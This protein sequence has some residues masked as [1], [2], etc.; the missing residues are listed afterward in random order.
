ML[1]AGLQLSLGQSLT[2]TP[3]LQQ[4]IRLLQLSSIE[5]QAEIREQLEN[6]PMLEL[7]ESSD[8][9]DPQERVGS[10]ELRSDD[11]QT[12][13]ENA[14]QPHD[15]RTSHEAEL[16]SGQYTDD[17]PEDLPMDTRWD[18][19]YDQ[20]NTSSRHGEID[21]RDP[22]E[23][24]ADSSEGLIDHLAWQIHLSPLGAIERDIA[25]HIIE[26]VRPDGYLEMS[27]VELHAAFLDQIRDAHFTEDDEGSDD[28]SPAVDDVSLDAF[29]AVQHWVQQ[30]D[31]VGCACET[32]RECLSAQLVALARE[33]RTATASSPVTS[34]TQAIDERDSTDHR[35]DVE[36]AFRIVGEEFDALGRRDHRALARRLGVPAEAI[37]RAIRVIQELDPRP[38][39]RFSSAPTE[40]IA[41][42]VYVVK[43][44]GIGW[45]ARINP[46]VAPN[47]RVNELYARYAREARNARDAEFMKGHLQEARWFLK[48]LQARNDTMLRVAQTI[49]DR[50]TGFLE[51]GEVGM[52]PMVLRDIAETLNLHESTISRVTQ[53]KYLHTPRG[54]YEF[55]YFFSSHVTTDGGGECSATAIRAMLRELIEGETPSRP[56]SDARLAAILQERGIQVARRTVAKY[57]ESMRIP[58]S[59]ERRLTA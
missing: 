59:S 18:D 27:I 55:K 21:D 14:D 33:T 20:P 26:S 41:P 6:N 51:H 37:Q 1:K 50:Q 30:L 39:T 48:S 17:I 42:D 56:L 45:Q 8:S 44:P 32:A 19:I 2:M 52:Q 53:G 47:L 40:Y 12:E 25:M 15:D 46:N 24:I 3:Q 10:D 5:L 28:L 34:D 35:N 23:R 38:G 49:V 9:G 29:V 31:P 36:L 4:A 22:F 58:S 11:L 7:D 13:S 54:V 16:D 43:A 57:R